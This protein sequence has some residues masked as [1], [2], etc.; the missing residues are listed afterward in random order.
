MRAYVIATGVI[1]GLLVIVHVW[2]MVEEPH[3]AKD[4]WFILV[5]A[6]CAGLSVLAWRISRRPRST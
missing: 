6:V 1:F 5:T 2:R 3:L 4:P